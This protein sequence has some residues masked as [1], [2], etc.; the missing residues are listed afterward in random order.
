MIL[1]KGK[2][3]IQDAVRVAQASR[4]RPGWVAPINSDDFISFAGGTPALL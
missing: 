4:L 3:C 2:F 1:M